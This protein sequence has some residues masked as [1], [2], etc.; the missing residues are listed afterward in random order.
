M[1]ARDAVVPALLAALVVVGVSG[2]GGR[3]QSSVSITIAGKREQVAAG[4]TLAQAVARFRVEPAAGS[5]LD[6]SGRLL[7]RDVFPGVLLVDGR[8]VPGVTRL[9]DGER[10]DTVAGRSRTEPL[11][12]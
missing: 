12:R 1:R 7:H 10:V 11:L 6:V 3:R 8:R 5:L 4:T 9:S 2:C